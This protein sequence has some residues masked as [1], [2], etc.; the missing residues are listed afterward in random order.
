[1]TSTKRNSESVWK[2]VE[3]LVDL[4]AAGMVQELILGAIPTPLLPIDT[5]HSSP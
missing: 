2:A 3:N 5:L 1:M 4:H